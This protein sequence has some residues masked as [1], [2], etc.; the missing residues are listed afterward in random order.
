MRNLAQVFSVA[1]GASAVKRIRTDGG[2]PFGGLYRCA[3][4]GQAGSAGLSLSWIE[5]RMHVQVAVAKVGKYATRES[6]DTF[7]M[8]ERPHGGLS[9]VLADGQRSGRGAKVISNLVARKAV[10]LLA[11]GARDGV[12]ARAAHDYL[13]AA[14]G[15]Q[16]RAD[17]Q[18][19][20][21]DLESRSVVVTR[22]TDCG[23][24]VIEEGVTRWLD[25]ESKPIGIYRNT[26]PAIDELPLR[27]GLGVVIFSDG[28]RH[29]GQR[30]NITFDVAA[31]VEGTL[32][33]PGD[34]PPTAQRLADSLLATAVNADGGFPQDDISVVALLVNPQPLPDQVRRLNVIFP[35][36]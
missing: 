12:A 21:V 14:R 27:P 32:H 19:L 1:R 23:A 29:A 26:R 15:G 10:S 13:F 17:L 25:R 5:D 34:S 31:V 35:L 3:G 16:V 24:L 6:G 4:D 8:V 30:T 33:A 2:P 36:P 9:L 22:N 20:S 7:E 28:V 18:I 11:E